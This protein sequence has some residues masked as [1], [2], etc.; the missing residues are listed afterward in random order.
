MM[1]IKKLADRGTPTKLVK[2]I[3]QWLAN[4]KI[5]WTNDMRIE[6]SESNNGMIEKQNTLPLMYADD[7]AILVWNKEENTAKTE[8]EKTIEETK[9]RLKERG[10]NLSEEKSQIIKFT[11][12]TKKDVP[13][14]KL[15]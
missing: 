9:R 15:A 2:L 6:L 10:L 7:I 1:L 12:K 8:L 11:T 4:R 5:K 14:E 3:R 13:T